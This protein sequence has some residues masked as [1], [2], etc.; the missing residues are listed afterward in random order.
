MQT[1]A[2]TCTTDTHAYRRHTLR[3]AHEETHAETHKYTY[4]LTYQIHMHTHTYNTYAHRG[5]IAQ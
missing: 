5:D 2:Y 4:V 1:Y 3:Y